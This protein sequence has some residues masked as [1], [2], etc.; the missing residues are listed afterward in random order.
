M[1]ALDVAPAVLGRLDQLARHGKLAC[2]VP[3]RRTLAA[4]TCR[5]LPAAAARAAATSYQC[6]A[7]TSFLP[8]PVL[9]S[10]PTARRIRCLSPRAPLSSAAVLAP[11]A[12]PVDHVRAGR[13]VA[14]GVTAGVEVKETAGASPGR[15]PAR[16]GPP[17][18]AARRRRPRRRALFARRRVG[19]R[20]RGERHAVGGD[21]R[22]DPACGV[23]T[24]ERRRLGRDGRGQDDVHAGD[25]R[26]LTRAG[27]ARSTPAADPW[28][29]VH[30]GARSRRHQG[31]S[32]NGALEALGEPA[33]EGP[34][35][36]IGHPVQERSVEDSPERPKRGDAKRGDVG[37][38]QDEAA[39]VGT[40]WGK[41]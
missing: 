18:L 13:R 40:E 24:A 12:A 26:A 35:G 23:G 28:H 6:C 33:E 9:A 29:T 7:P 30:K 10:L 31:R 41:F 22:A 27:R 16:T 25:A 36:R 20:A 2:R 32:A 1:D 3:G 37:G 38:R 8:S 15:F 4:A 17:D 19:R 21:G 34:S 14:F 11:T 5:T 39:P